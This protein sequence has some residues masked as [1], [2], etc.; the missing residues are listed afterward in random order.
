M[1]IKILPLLLY[2]TVKQLTWNCKDELLGHINSTSDIL[3]LVGKRCQY[4]LC[5]PKDQS[6]I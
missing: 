4:D 3:F 1:P 6:K 5:E 2:L